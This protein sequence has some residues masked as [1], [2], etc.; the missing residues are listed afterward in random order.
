M[1]ERVVNKVKTRRELILE[2]H[3]SRGIEEEDDK[4]KGDEKKRSE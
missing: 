4:H 3:R 1:R 2:D